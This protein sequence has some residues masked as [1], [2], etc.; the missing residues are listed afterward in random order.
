MGDDW[1]LRPCVGLYY[2]ESELRLNPLI[3]DFLWPGLQCAWR[4]I[5]SKGHFVVDSSPYLF[6]AP[7]KAHCL[8]TLGNGVCYHHSRKGVVMDKIFEP[9][10]TVLLA[11]PKTKRRVLTRIIALS[12][13]PDEDGK[14]I[15]D[16][17]RV[18]GNST[19][20][21][22]DEAWYVFRFKLGQP[23][24]YVFGHQ[25][26]RVEVSTVEEIHFWEDGRAEERYVV[27][28]GG[29]P[30]AADKLFATKEEALV[31][32]EARKQHV[33]GLKAQKALRRQRRRAA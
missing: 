10:Q 24:Y 32:W 22:A 23:V 14:V 7:W 15:Y 30:I 1:S 3:G 28:L 2:R 8:K 12:I 20:S 18:A 27:R 17:P 29:K 5:I 26:F 4:W 6:L 13:W 19:L 25:T 21:C 31:A 11:V 33:A 16:I 9:G